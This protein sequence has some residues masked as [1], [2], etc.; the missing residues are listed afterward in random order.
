MLN[1]QYAAE[2]TGKQM[3]L[4][5]W[6]EIGTT[7]CLNFSTGFFSFQGQISGMGLAQAKTIGSLAIALIHSGNDIGAG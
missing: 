3:E 7:G 1:V 4:L 2:D 6:L 5:T